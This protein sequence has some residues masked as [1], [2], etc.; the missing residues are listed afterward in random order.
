M[1]HFVTELQVNTLSVAFFDKNESRLRLGAV[2]TGVIRSNKGVTG[3]RAI[4]NFPRILIFFSFG[5]SH[6]QTSVAGNLQCFERH[7]VYG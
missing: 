5:R 1:A 3:G 7:S 2:L 4:F 6:V